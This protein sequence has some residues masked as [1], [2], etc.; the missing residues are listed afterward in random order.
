MSPKELAEKTIRDIAAKR[1]KEDKEFYNYQRESGIK[2]RKG[3]SI[4]YGGYRW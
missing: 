2:R 4:K 3:C 1:A